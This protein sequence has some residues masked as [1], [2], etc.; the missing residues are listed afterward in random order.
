MKKSIYLFLLF[1]FLFEGQVRAEA[2][3]VSQLPIVVRT[4]PEWMKNYPTVINNWD[5]KFITSVEGELPPLLSV[6]TSINGKDT[7]G[8][9]ESEFNTLLL[10]QSASNIS[11]LIKKGG[12]NIS[13]QCTIHY[14]P[15]IYW[16]EGITLNDP[17]PIPDN[18]TMKNMKGASVFSFNTFAFRTGNIEGINEEEVLKAASRSLSK[19]GYVQIEDEEKADIVVS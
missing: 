15:S 8:M 13:C 19:M 1:L 10:S 14:H 9:K 2:F 7:K 5:G 17:E 3:D 18:I 11:Y 12:K 4:M 16:A 6:I